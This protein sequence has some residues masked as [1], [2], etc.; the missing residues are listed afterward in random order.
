MRV[1]RESIR[2]SNSRTYGPKR[3]PHRST[4]NVQ[5]REVSLATEN[6]H[7]SEPTW[8]DLTRECSPGK[9]EGERWH[10][11]TQRMASVGPSAGEDSR[12]LSAGARRGPAIVAN[13]HGLRQGGHRDPDQRRGAAAALVS[14][15]VDLRG[16]DGRHTG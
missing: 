10:T 16:A 15:T 14:C 2:S 6:G 13:K 1:H 5:G 7:F 11:T 3:S 9:Q 4:E 12:S 8:F